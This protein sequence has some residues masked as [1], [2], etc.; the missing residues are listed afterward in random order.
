MRRQAP[1]EP[2]SLREWASAWELEPELQ[3]Q[4]GKPAQRFWG[5]PERAL[6]QAPGQA[7]EPASTRGRV[8]PWEPMPELQAQQEKPERHCGEL[9]EPAWRLKLL[10]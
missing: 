5:L 1:W 10:L 8:P 6:L 2:A 7:W 9:P 3:A 4:Q